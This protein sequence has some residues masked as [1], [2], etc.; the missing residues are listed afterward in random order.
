MGYNGSTYEDFRA[1][2]PDDVHLEVGLN[3]LHN[4]LLQLRLELGWH[5]VL[6]WTVWMISL[7]WTGFRRIPGQDAAL[8][9]TVAFALLALLI[10]GL[11]EYNFGDSEILK[12]YLVLFGLIDVF[13]LAAG[14]KRNGRSDTLRGEPA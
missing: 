14:E 3:H 11:V 12:L 4:N 2:I 8:R 13:G 7:L 10:N 5:G 1:A 9:H 6:L